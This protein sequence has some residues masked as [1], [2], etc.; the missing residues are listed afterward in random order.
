MAGINLGD[1]WNE[2]KENYA[3]DWDVS[4]DGLTKE[5]DSNNH[6]YINLRFDENKRINNMTMSFQTSLENTVKLL[7][8][9]QLLETKYSL[10]YEQ[11]S[12]TSWKMKTED[13]YNVHIMYS[14][15][16]GKDKTNSSLLV[17]VENF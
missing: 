8:L 16:L 1:N 7:E 4:N 17:R 6:I 14:D 10:V 13:L 5:W 3:K 2:I 12:E 9:K 11:T 15:K